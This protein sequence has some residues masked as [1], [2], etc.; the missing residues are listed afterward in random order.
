MPL[1][2]GTRAAGLQTSLG[3]TTRFGVIGIM[4]AAI[5]FGMFNLILVA[6]PI[7][8]GPIVL[9]AN[10]IGFSVAIAASFVLNARYTFRVPARKRQFWGYVA[11]SVTGLALYN[12][13]LALLLLAWHPN[14]F[15]GF[16]VLKSAS[17]VASTVWNFLGYR[18]LVFRAD[19]I[20]ATEA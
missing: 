15:V 12:G 6:S 8:S 1:L 10:T 16:N 7:D 13:A 3:M 9:L 11:V 19:P 18:Y 20:S 5:D 2:P 4:K 17:L 14:S